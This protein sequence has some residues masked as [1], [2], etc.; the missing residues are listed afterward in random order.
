MVA[1]ELNEIAF[2]ELDASQVAELARCSGASHERYE[3]GT[4]LIEVGDRD[5]KFHVVTKGAIEILDVS[6]DAPRSITFHRPGAFSGDVSH[7]TGN[8][9]VIRAVARGATE[10]WAV[11]SSTLRD[12]LN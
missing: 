9:S 7:L 10:A 12:M 1:H 2:P 3:D 4:T 8:P 11:S 5:F 6:G